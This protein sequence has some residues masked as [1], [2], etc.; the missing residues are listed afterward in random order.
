MPALW[1]YCRDLYQTPGFGE[2]IDWYQVKA[3]Y[4]GV[5]K[6]IN[7]TG[8]IPLGPADPGWDSPHGREA[9]S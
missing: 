1:G 9:L 6:N 2:T 3:H 5:H 8:V 4:Y 7:P